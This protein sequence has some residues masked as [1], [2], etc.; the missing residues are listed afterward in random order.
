MASGAGVGS[1]PGVAPPEVGVGGEVASPSGPPLPHVL[2]PEEEHIVG[3]NHAV[4]TVHTTQ[5]LPRPSS[6]APHRH[7]GHLLPSR[8]VGAF[9]WMLKKERDQR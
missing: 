4:S 7:L 9:S 5:A 3:S 8:C 6:H 2:F 1:G